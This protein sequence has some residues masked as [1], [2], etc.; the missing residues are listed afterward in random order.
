MSN[1]IPDGT[2]DIKILADGTVRAETASMAGPS[3]KAADD[4]MKSLAALMGGDMEVLKLKPHQH[5]HHGDD[6]DHEHEHA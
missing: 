2:M 6:H 5:H 4:F 3:H 1:P